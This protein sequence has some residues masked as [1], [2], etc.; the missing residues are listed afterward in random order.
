MTKTVVYEEFE[1]G[2]P[3]PDGLEA[4]KTPASDAQGAGV[5]ETKTAAAEKPAPAEAK[6]NK[7][8]ERRI[9]ELEASERYWA[10]QAKKTAPIA[11]KKADQPDEIEA[12][13]AGPGV[14]G[15][16]AAAL[17]DEI[18][19]K[20]IAALE[21][22]G[23]V[24]ADKMR[25]V[26]AAVERRMEAKAA[27]IAEGRVNGAKDQLTAEAK[28]LQEY[29]DLA[30]DKSEFAVAVGREFAAM[31]AEDPSLKNSYGALRM[32]AK[33]VKQ[34]QGGTSAA[35]DRARRIDAQSP[36]RGSRPAPDSEE[37]D[38]TPEARMLIAAGARYGVTE[39]SY[40]ANARRSR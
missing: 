19:E 21:K 34:T 12:L 26:I 32:A 38:I 20:G 8:Y 37:I 25:Q 16:T 27:A 24:T 39:E 31:V 4:G 3:G 17:L 9:A 10:E 6:V 28:L 30:N 35:A 18:G 36:T 22:R 14:D 7:D 5:T 33:L 29:P 11:E 1:P 40:R 13:L 2:T 15:D 23:V